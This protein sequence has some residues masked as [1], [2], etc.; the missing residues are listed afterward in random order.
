MSLKGFHIV[1]VTL[2]SLLAFVFGG[3]SLRFYTTGGGSTYLTLGGASF[4]VGLI[5]IFY[6]FWFWRKINTREEERRRRRKNIHPVPVV[7][8]I[9]ML[10]QR[11]AWACTVCYGD[12]EGP[13]I[14]GARSGVYLLF[15]VVLAVQAA[16]VLFFVYLWRRA[17]RYRRG[18]L[19]L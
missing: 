6:G 19:E 13:L 4:A 15:G 9:W 3:W 2:S 17:R 18:E 14:E 7:L 5:L 11:A 12:A 1:F 10:S 8:A 16:F